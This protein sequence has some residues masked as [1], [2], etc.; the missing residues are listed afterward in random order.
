M[1]HLLIFL[2]LILPASLAQSQE[3]AEKMSLDGLL[4]AVRS[5]R[6]A[7]S[8]DNAQRLARFKNENSDRKKM[9]AD[10]IA[11]ERKQEAI[12]KQREASFEKNEKAIGELE[13]RL[14]ERM[15]S[16]KE[17]FGVLQ[18]VASDA[19]AQFHSSL[20]QLEFRD[21]T[22]FLID[23]AGR[24]GE[25]NRLPE[26]AEIEKLWFELQREMVESG[27]VVTRAQAVVD[28]KGQ[29]VERQVTRIGLFNA[30]ADGKYL[31]YVPET[32]RLLEFARQPESRY[33]Q[34][35]RAIASGEDEVGRTRMANLGIEPPNQ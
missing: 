33:M 9:L 23:F 35:P 30:V 8:Q 15:G 1:K 2:L 20:T 28:S 34:G 26:L 22:D 16:L 11:E 25:A 14:S 32:G 6:I 3:E 10:I 21:R 7:E 12:S 29:E 24:M 4:E 27:R 19:Q 18:Q 13:E 31:Q 5:G 17:L